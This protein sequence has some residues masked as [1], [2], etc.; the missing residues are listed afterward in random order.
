MSTWRVNWQH[1][2]EDSSWWS[3][4]IVR[5]D[6]AEEAAEKMVHLVADHTSHTDKRLLVRVYGPL[7][8]DYEEFYVSEAVKVESA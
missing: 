3:D 1:R 4:S 6:T 5:A 7:P 2:R 8:E